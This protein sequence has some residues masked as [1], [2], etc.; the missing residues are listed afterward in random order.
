MKSTPKFCLILILSML[1]PTLARAAD[2]RELTTNSAIYLLHSAMKEQYKGREIPLLKSLRQLKDPQLAPLFEELAR[3]PHPILKIHGI[4]GLAEC[5]PQKKLDLL[6]IAS[7]DQSTVQIQV[8]AAAIDS[9][10]L[11]DE[12][13]NQL[14]N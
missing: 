12:E 6:R 5:Q 4:L 11:S 3:Y 14:I 1:L 7:I 9:G 2:E 8:I 13:A 10:L